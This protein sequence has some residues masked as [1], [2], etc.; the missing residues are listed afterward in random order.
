MDNVN[1]R[2]ITDDYYVVRAKHTNRGLHRHEGYE[3][4]YVLSGEC[5]H[6][7]YCGYSQYQQ[8]LRQG[9]FIVLDNSV[10]HRFQNGNKDFCIINFLFKPKFI[11]GDEAFSRILLSEGEKIFNTLQYDETGTLLS[12]F[13][14]A[15]NAYIRGGY[16]G[17]A[18]AACYAREII[19]STLCLGEAIKSKDDIASKILTII[20]EKFSEQITL[21]AIC[22]ELHYSLPY[23]SRKFK[24]KH[25]ISFEK[26]LQNVRIKHACMLL[27]ST[28]LAINEIALSVS[29]SD[30]DAFRR[31][32]FLRTGKTPSAF[33]KAHK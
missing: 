25:L 15:Q 18:L 33:R 11:L 14:K 30:V 17:H 3:A 12:L 20:E 22:E 8:K 2:T 19:L 29:Y 24:E 16:K 10:A 6:I 4:F 7:L 26:Y 31:I 28:D 13:E 23:T 21:G 9:N 1:V 32:F 5:E 27:I